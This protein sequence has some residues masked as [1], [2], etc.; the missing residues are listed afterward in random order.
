MKRTW[1]SI[2]ATC[3]SF[4]L[5]AVASVPATAESGSMKGDI[6]MDMTQELRLSDEGTVY[7][8]SSSLGNDQNDGLSEAT[9][10]KSFSHIEG[11][12]LKPGDRVL[13]RRGDVW[14]E[15]LTVRGN[16]R[17]D[18]W[19]FVGAYGDLSDPKPE[20]SLDNGKD[21]IAVLATDISVGARNGF[22]LNYIWIDNL[23]ISHSFLGIYFRYDTSTDNKGIR[24]TNC[25]FSRIHC[26]E[27]MQEALTDVSFLTQTKGGL[28]DYQNGALV[29]NGG[30][31]AEYI[32]PTAINI[33]GRPARPLADVTVPG[34]AEPANLISEIE[35]YQNQFDECVIA[36]GA[37]CYNYHYGTGPNQCYTYTTNW[38]I[39]GL[40]AT[41]TM[42]VINIDSADFGYDGTAESRWG[43]W[44]HIQ[45][46]SGMAD[47]TMAFGTTQ[48]LFSCCR[49]LYISHSSFNDCHNNG[50]PDGCGFDF[51]RSVHN[52]TLDACI[53]AN[54]QGQ[55]VLV[56]QTT[57]ENQVTGEQVNTP[58][59]NNTIENC[60]FYNNMTSVHNENYRYDITVF[61]TDN[62]DFTL[63]NNSFYFRVRTAGGAKVPINQLT[64][65]T[66]SPY[67]PERAGFTETDSRLVRNSDMPP[68]ADV[69]AELG[70][71]ESV[72]EYLPVEKTWFNY[73]DEG[74]DHAETAEE[75]DGDDTEPDTSGTGM[76]TDENQ[77]TGDETQPATDRTQPTDAGYEPSADE[78]SLT[79]SGTG[80]SGT[81]CRS[82]LYGTAVAV[83]G[84]TAA[85]VGA[86][87]W[88]TARRR[89][90]K[91]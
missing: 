46:K 86:T 90:K 50:Q 14:H 22:G 12:D 79:Q 32:W 38:N 52:F 89:K 77:P 2:L 45:A 78:P 63:R 71:D 20:I 21:D 29:E 42:T 73:T 88:L 30:G 69:V 39:D 55:G 19:I 23:H 57:M 16:G 33:G 76:V 83:I 43:R 27:L 62:T 58:N 72:K 49:N 41:D 51:E 66:Y 87:A 6:R 36:V 5:L 34:V 37:N 13:L 61:N 60:L 53:F 1:F 64:S 8:V 7:Y 54:N 15:R 47:F 3:L 40:T 67:G 68:L 25:A 74:A 26:P 31:V 56:M 81:G 10:W 59:T 11:M 17:E 91:E 9:P 84:A 65:K 48:A 35:L 85:V 44:S 70:M 18:A 28:E 75:T 4:G 80:E 82:S 24:V